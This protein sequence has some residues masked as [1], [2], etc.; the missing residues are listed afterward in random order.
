[1]KR[2]L[3]ISHSCFPVNGAEEIVNIRLLSA[4]SQSGKFTIDVV[5]KKKKLAQ[6][7]SEALDKYNVQLNSL[8]MIEVDNRITLTTIFQHVKAFF[9]FGLVHKG[10]HWA[11]QALP[12][13]IKLVKENH[14]DY[15]LTRAAPAHYIGYYLKKKYGVKWVCTWNDP[16]PLS[17]Y[18]F[19]YGQ[20]NGRDMI[21]HNAKEIKIMKY[22]DVYIYP[23]QR[24]AAYMNQ[25]LQS[26]KS[27]IHIIPHVI[28][29][30][31]HK[32]KAF[33]GGTLKFIH[34]GKCIT[35]RSATNLLVALNELLS[36]NIISKSTLSFTFMGKLNAVDE[37]MISS[38]SLSE[39]VKVI[40]P[41]PYLE[42]LKILKEYDVAVII[43]AP[44]TEGIFLPTKVSDF[45]YESKRILTLS[46]KNGLLHDL[47]DEGYVS[48]FADVENVKS[49][50]NAIMKIVED[51]KKSQ[52][53]EFTVKIP[54][55]Y[56]PQYVVKK[57]LS[58]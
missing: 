50:K 2:I 3:F 19:P 7:P 6:Y 58:F 52:W 34:S 18:P 46:P 35:P 43:E 33:T 37:Q 12:M 11:A 8:H 45:M 27:N 14:Y 4:L 29:G 41:V 38:T 10:D 55:K 5:T 47:Y 24:L 22:S 56:E 23:N 17:M 9:H 28:L 30:R 36:S 51:C 44:C 26:D 49:I 53:N 21:T 15:V 42:S 31:P 1:M 40:E 16:Q 20:G 48:Y 57:Y 25:Y 54:E 13:A 32:P 39:I